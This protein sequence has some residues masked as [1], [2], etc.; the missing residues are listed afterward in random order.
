MSEIHQI[1]YGN[2]NCYIVS[3]GSNAIL[4]DTGRE[5]Y[6]EKILKKCRNFN[7]RLI[8][9]TH[10]HVD[11]IQ[12]TAFLA[13]QLKVP[14][15]MSKSDISLIRDNMTQQMFLRGFLGKIILSASIKS[16]RKDEILPFMPTVFLNDGD[17]LNEYGI[18]A[19]IIDLAGHT[20]G[21]IGIDVDNESL[22]VGD[23]LMN[24][25]YPTV[26]HIYTDRDMMIK[27]AEKISN[28]GNRKIYFGHGNPVNNK[29]WIKR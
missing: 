8:V 23:A 24:M 21:S 5:K 20:K 25:F 28:L 12:N 7:I 17:S 26:S 18:P 19:K 6:K 3:N 14:V 29:V 4:V 10:G 13:E 2:V 9:L 16:F 27:S 11:H 15:A 22:I 1:K